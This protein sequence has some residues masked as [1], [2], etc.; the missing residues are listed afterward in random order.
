MIGDGGI[1]TYLGELL[2]RIAD[3]R[4]RWRLTVLGPPDRL[5]PLGARP[6]VDVREL[7]T[8]IYGL[9]EQLDLARVAARGDLFWAPH[10]NVPLA[11]G[12]RLAVTI[13]DVAHLALAGLVGPV[14]RLY[15]RAMFA[16][17]RR[18]ARALLF[19]T[20]FSADEFARLV[21]APR[22]PATVAHLGV[23]EE[24]ARARETHP[25]RPLAEPYLLY[26]GNFKRHKNV[27]GLLRAF[28][29]ARERMPHRLVL[30]GRSEGLRADPEIPPLLRELG[31]AVVVPGEIAQDAL[32]GWVAHADALVT[33]SRYEGFGLP[34]LEAMAAGVPTMV[35]AAG[36]LPEVCG[37]ASLYCHPHD[38]RNVAERMVQVATDRELRALLVAAGRARAA[39]FRWDRCARLTVEALEGALA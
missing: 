10:Y 28:R 7:R 39:E 38:E 8:P 3:D 17:V 15:A 27:P 32:R 36:S 6:N 20:R 11:T 14:E 23:G 13:H 22:C 25:A 16:A 35:S 2:P 12:M 30:I 33:A 21:G 5:A 18:R 9:R 24:W 26:V 29:R 34:P 37:D 31:D 4:P 1:G 19:D